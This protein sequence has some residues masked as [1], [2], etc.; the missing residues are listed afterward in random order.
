[1]HD[2]AKK[3]VKKEGLITADQG[4]RGAEGRMVPCLSQD[5][6]SGTIKVNLPL[7]QQ[8]VKPAI[9]PLLGTRRRQR[10]APLCG[11]QVR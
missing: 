1:M 2:G 5:A 10:K 3:G 8:V 7:I 9:S 11:A 6:L 4:V